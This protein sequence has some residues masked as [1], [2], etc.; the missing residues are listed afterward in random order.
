[1]P[2][3]WRWKGCLNLNTAG[4]TAGNTTCDRIYRGIS[5][6]YKW[7]GLSLSGWKIKSPAQDPPFL[8]LCGEKILLFKIYCSDT[9]WIVHEYRHAYIFTHVYTL[10]SLCVCYVTVCCLFVHLSSCIRHVWPA[11]CHFITLVSIAPTLVC[12]P[13]YAVLIP[14]LIPSLIFPLLSK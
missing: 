4:N 5:R 3:N 7:C 9:C 6:R 13:I 11:S 12:F 2:A 8:A 14:S 10:V 1:M